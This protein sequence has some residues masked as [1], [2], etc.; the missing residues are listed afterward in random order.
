MFKMLEYFIL[1]RIDFITLNRISPS[2]VSGFRYF[3]RYS[4]NPTSQSRKS[5]PYKSE[6]ETCSDGFEP[7]SPF[8]MTVDLLSVGRL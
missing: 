8:N 1:N 7:C 4:S 6:L 5:V 2:P 3:S